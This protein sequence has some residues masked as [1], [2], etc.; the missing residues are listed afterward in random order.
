MEKEN[1]VTCV[2][3]TCVVA[4]LGLVVGIAFFISETS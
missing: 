1:D 4:L 3:F 2:A